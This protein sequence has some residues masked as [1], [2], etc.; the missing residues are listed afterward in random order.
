MRARLKSIHAVGISGPLDSYVPDD[1]EHFGFP[2]MVFIGPSDSDLVDSF[3]ALVCTPSWLGEN[4]DDPRVS[5][6][7]FESPGAIFGNR[8]IFLR[9]WDYVALVDAITGLCAFHEAGDWGMLADRLGRHIPWEYD[10][11]YDAF[12]DERKDEVPCFPPERS[13]SG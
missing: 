3:D 1:P 9:R 11:R 10:Y 2:I 13:S 12:L 6:W 7:S 8:C 4:F 5:R